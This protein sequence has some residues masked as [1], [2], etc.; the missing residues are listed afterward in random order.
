MCFIDKGEM[1]ELF[2]DGR[3]DFYGMSIFFYKKSL[4]YIMEFRILFV[5]VEF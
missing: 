1:R 2:R 4:K 3:F 5:N